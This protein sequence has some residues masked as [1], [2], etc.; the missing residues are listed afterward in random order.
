MKINVSLTLNM[1]PRHFSYVA[2][3]KHG[4]AQP[5]SGRVLT[6]PMVANGFTPSLVSCANDFVPAPTQNV[7][8]HSQPK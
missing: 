6:L 4:A 1:R 5:D 8:A 2:Y 3:I 7:L